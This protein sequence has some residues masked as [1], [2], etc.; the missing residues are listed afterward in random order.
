MDVNKSRPK[1]L[2]VDDAPENIHVL[3]KALKQ[4]Y[5]V[6]AATSGEKALEVAFSDIPPQIILLDIIMPGIDGYEVCRRLKNSPKTADIPIIFVTA[7]EDAVDETKGLSLGAIDY[8]TKPFN[9]NIVRARVG[10]HLQLV[11]AMRIKDDVD[12]M[13][14]HDLKNPLSVVITNPCIIKLSKEIGEIESSMLDDIELAGY[15]MLNMINSSLDLFKI[16]KG[17][18]RPELISFNIIEKLQLIDRQLSPLA[19]AMDI[20]I[21]FSLDENKLNKSSFCYVIGVELLFYAAISNLTKNALEASPEGAEVRIAIK[22]SE[23]CELEIHNKGMVPEQLQNNFFDK[24]VTSGKEGGTG[25]GTYSAKLFIE[26]MGGSINMNT[27]ENT[28]TSVVVKIPMDRCS[29]K[30]STNNASGL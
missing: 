30:E 28:G 22:S 18:Y 12:R 24:Y 25:L 10:N 9:P 8:I 20:K 21:K 7:L 1:V 29:N 4:D 26:A 23:V 11:E 5:A 3:L 13:M 27:S 2:I 14:R 6:I 19:E 16:E 17:S 15:T